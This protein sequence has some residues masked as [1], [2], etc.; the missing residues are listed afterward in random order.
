MLAGN[1]ALTRRRVISAA[2][3][4]GLAVVLGACTASIERT[5]RRRTPT[6]PLPRSGDENLLLAAIADEEDLLGYCV[7]V[8]SQHRGLATVAAPVRQRQRQHVDT[9]R[10]ALRRLDPP[11]TRREVLVPAR[12]RTAEDKLRR[13]IAAAQRSR[14][15]DCLKADSGPLARLLASTSASHA[16]TVDVLKAQ[17]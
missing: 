1:D 3:A 9:F 15:E 6:P 10:S 8:L 4:A 14:F 13:L 2:G 11:P 5:V 7:A 17:Q 16:V 12:A